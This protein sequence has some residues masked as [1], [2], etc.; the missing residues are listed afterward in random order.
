MRRPFRNLAAT[1]L[2]AGLAL[3]G[4]SV[5]QA[6][7]VGTLK[8]F[9]TPTANSSPSHITEGSDGNLW[10]TESPNVDPQN[11]G[12]ITPSGD[13]TEFAACNSCFPNDIAQGPDN[14]LYYTNNDNLLG[15]MTTDGQSLAPVSQ[16]VF[17]GGNRLAVHGDIVWIT[18]FNRD[19]IWR[20][21]TTAADPSTAFTSFAPPTPGSNPGDIAV[22]KAG[23]VWF[24]ENSPSPGAIA[25]F[26]P[27]AAVGEQFTET[28]VPAG[29]GFPRSIAVATDA[30]GTIWYTRTVSDRVGRLAP[31]TLQVTETPLRAET[32]PAEIAPAADG[33]MWF[34]QSFA[35]NIAHI[36]PQGVVLGESKVVKSSEPAGITVATDGNPWYVDNAG[37]KVDA[38]LLR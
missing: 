25:R 32:E 29:E 12:R 8:Q 9:K 31:V 28:P 14:I 37:S 5:A 23:I 11:I 22:D 27:T 3:A 18:D 6:A 15:R 34:T 2:V 26:D 1:T 13:I 30:A 10:F 16:G 35:G 24:T 20:Y 38:F 17:V 4:A 7:S 33:S 36:S 19:V 21:D